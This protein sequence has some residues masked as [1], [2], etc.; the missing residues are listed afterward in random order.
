M[1]KHTPGP[2]AKQT[3]R[4]ITRE[5][6]RDEFREWFRGTKEECDGYTFNFVGDGI[7]FFYV[8]AIA[9]AEGGAA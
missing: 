7:G 9:K 2:L 6:K 8:Q 1:S 5:T 3:H 4:V